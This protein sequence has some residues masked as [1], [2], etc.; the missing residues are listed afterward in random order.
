ML[1]CTWGPALLSPV[2]PIATRI[3]SSNAGERGPRMNAECGNSMPPSRQ[4]ILQHIDNYCTNFGNRSREWFSQQANGLLHYSCTLLRELWNLCIFGNIRSKI[5]VLKV[6]CTRHEQG[7]VVF[8]LY[9]V[10]TCVLF[11]EVI[12]VNFKCCER[13]INSL[14]PVDN[15]GCSVQPPSR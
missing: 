4:D 3:P 15:D 12:I 6:L 8:V 11:V 9:F 10:L 7:L 13:P 5:W 1:Q 2:A 14:W